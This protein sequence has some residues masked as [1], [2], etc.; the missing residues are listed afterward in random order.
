MLI[1]NS[2][3]FDKNKQ[4][5]S[6]TAASP[7]DSHTS[8]IQC[9]K[10]QNNQ[11]FKLHIINE[12]LLQ[13]QWTQITPEIHTEQVSVMNTINLTPTNIQQKQ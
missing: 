11:S 5:I 13:V 10:I 8:K 2:K 1:Q 6:C 7:S 3:I 4:N 9:D 12:I